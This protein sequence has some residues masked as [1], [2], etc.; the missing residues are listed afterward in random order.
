MLPNSISLYIRNRTGVISESEILSLSTSN[1][2]GILDILPGH[3]QFISLVDGEIIIRYLDGRIE[4]ML[5]PNS[6]LKVYQNKISIYIG[7]KNT[8]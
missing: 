3:E 8:R 4:K 6:V 1:T 7:V 5:V 2:K